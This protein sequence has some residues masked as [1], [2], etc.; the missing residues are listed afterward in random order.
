MPYRI[1]KTIEV[2]SGHMLSKHP[3]NC[4]FPHGHTR[5]IELVLESDT[6]DKND[7]VCDYKVLK[8]VLQEFDSTLDHAICMNTDDPMFATFKERYG[9]RVVGFENQDPTTE[10]LTKMI[11]DRVKTFLSD[12]QQR[13]DA[14]YPIGGQVKLIRIRLWETTSSWSEYEE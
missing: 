10:V 14:K 2:E 5:K 6:L 12:Y 3:D 13:P 9:D 11:Y 1:C 7:M 8:E 4:K